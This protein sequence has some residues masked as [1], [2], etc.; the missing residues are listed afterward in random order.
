MTMRTYTYLWLALTLFMAF[1]Y[2]ALNSH[3]SLSF[4]NFIK[5]HGHRFRELNLSTEAGRPIS[6]YLGVVGFGFILMT[7]PYTWRKKWS[8][9]K[10]IGTLTGWLEFHIFCG[11]FGPTCI[12][13]HSGFKVRGL[14][15]ISF[16]SMIIVAVSGVIGRYIY[17]QILRE[18]K[19]TS[20]DIKVMDERLEKMRVQA[21]EKV[22][23]QDLI[24]AKELALH[25]VGLPDGVEGA[26]RRSLVGVLLSSFWGDLRLL[27]SAPPIVPGLPERSRYLLAAN[28]LNQRRSVLLE[29]FRRM[30][31]YWHSFHLPFAVF[32]YLAAVIHIAAALMFGIGA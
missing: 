30:L 23:V 7:N 4:A 16:W 6:F 15:G 28:A 10:K 14:V 25:F 22:T 29:T 3:L 2:W 27:F 12:I 32:M 11:L 1:E 31:G 20:Q 13:F 9:L 21:G 17:V 24:L 19:L 18:E 8:I 26:K 5:T